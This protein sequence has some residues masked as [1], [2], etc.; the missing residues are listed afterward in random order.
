MVLSIAFVN[1]ASRIIVGGIKRNN[2]QRNI[3]FD[4]GIIGN[5]MARR[6]K[7]PANVVD[8]CEDALPEAEVSK[9]ARGADDDRRMDEKGQEDLIAARVKK[10]NDSTYTC[11]K[12]TMIASVIVFLLKLDEDAR[13]WRELGPRI[14]WKFGLFLGVEVVME[15]VAMVI[16]ERLSGGIPI[17]DFEPLDGIGVLKQSWFAASQAMF[18]F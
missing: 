9:E 12:G 8:V 13:G 2:I 4:F 15:S 17:G 5:V 6:R 10:R 18:Y 3:D 16:E 11:Y 1:K 14:L 7:R